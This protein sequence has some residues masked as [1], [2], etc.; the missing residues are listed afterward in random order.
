MIKCEERV[1][2]CE[3]RVIKCEERVIKSEERVIKCENR[4]IKWLI[5]EIFKFKIYKTMFNNKKT[6]F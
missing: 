6:I 3:E 5:D 4:V 1:I 2:K